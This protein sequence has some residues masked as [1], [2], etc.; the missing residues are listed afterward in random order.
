MGHGRQTMHLPLHDDDS[1][2]LHTTYSAG[3][4]TPLGL[5]PLA[6]HQRANVAIVG[7]GITGCSTALRFVAK[8]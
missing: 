4:G 8:R 1:R 6:G 5:G 3:A 7:G 2:P